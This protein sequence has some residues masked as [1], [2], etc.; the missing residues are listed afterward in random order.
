MIMNSIEKEKTIFEAWLESNEITSL[1]FDEFQK[2]RK[3][4]SANEY[5]NYLGLSSNDIE[6]KYCFTYAIP[7]HIEIK[8]DYSYLLS[9][10]RSYYSANTEKELEELEKKLYEFCIEEK[11]IKN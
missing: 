3:K 8:D 7:V 9:I 6:A 4:I 10:E 1:S 11:S 5:E 2:S